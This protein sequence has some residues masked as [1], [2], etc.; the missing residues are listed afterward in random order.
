MIERDDVDKLE[1]LIGQLDAVF[2]EI[3][4]LSKKT[5]N[6]AVNAF[7][8]NFVN[9]ILN[10][11]NDFLGELYKPFESFNDFNADDLPSNSD[12]SFIMKQYMQAT[13]KYRSDNIHISIGNWYYNL[14][15]GEGSVAAAPPAKIT[16]K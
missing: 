10:D 16:K 1:R 15:E 6:D 14:P 7:K 3:E 12:V 8:L 13:E 4:K 9:G 5:P 2:L 11:C